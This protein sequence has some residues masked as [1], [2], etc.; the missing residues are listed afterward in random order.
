M[1]FKYLPENRSL[2]PVE[3]ILSSGTGLLIP[4]S[5]PGE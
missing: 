3:I 2:K 5:C 1:Y 4:S